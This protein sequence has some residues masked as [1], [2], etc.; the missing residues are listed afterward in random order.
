MSETTDWENSTLGVEL[1]SEYMNKPDYVG[2]KF[3]AKILGSNLSKPRDN[4]PQKPVLHMMVGDKQVQFD[5]SIANKNWLVSNIGKTPKSW[6]GE[7]IF[8]TCVPISYVD[9]VTNETKSG[10]SVAFSL[11]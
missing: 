5:L 8:F 2:K 7:T 4:R 3:R 6:I 9:R 1:I 10:Y 11:E